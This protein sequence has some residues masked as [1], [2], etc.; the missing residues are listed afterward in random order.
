MGP[1]K[2]MEMQTRCD[3]AQ[4]SDIP[5]DLARQVLAHRF[6]LGVTVFSTFSRLVLTTAPFFTC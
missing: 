4:R 2:G 5:L 3:G 6:G 1:G